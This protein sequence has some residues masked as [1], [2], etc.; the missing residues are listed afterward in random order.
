[1]LRATGWG[2]NLGEMGSES[3][4]GFFLELWKCSKVVVMVAQFCE[5]TENLWVVP[6]KRWI[7]WYMNY[8]AIKLLKNQTIAI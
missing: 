2:W 8:I 3:V 7:V 4:W 5:Y 1:M 6:F